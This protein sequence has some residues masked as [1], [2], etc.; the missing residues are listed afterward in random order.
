ME[1]INATTMQ[2]GYT[3]GMQHDGRDLL[4]VV[5]KGTFTIPQNGEEPKLADEQRAL[6]ETDVFTGEPGFSAP[7]YENDFAPR[8]PR[9]DVLLNGSAYAPHGKPTKRLCVSLRVGSLTKSFHVL[10][11]RVWKAGLLY[12]AASAPEP[13]TVMPI[14]YNNAFGGVDR[15]RE[16]ETQHRYYMLN[17]VGI[18]YH[19]YHDRKSLNGMPLPN[20]EETGKPIAK[21]DGKYRPMAFGPLGRAW[22]QRVKYAGTYD[23]N[24]IDNVFPFLPADFEDEYYQAAPEDQWMDY[25]KGGEVVELIN[26]LPHGGTVF[27]LPARTVSCEFFYKNGDRTEMNSVIDTILFEPDLGHFMMSWRCTLP[28][29]KNIHELRSIACS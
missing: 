15:S 12:T 27:Q 1:L 7:L 11:K 14:S 24:W 4:V 21:P 22:Q 18:G 8:K 28:L 6:V 5:V 17:H 29:R 16:D 23:Q 10:G 25:P 13:F 26:L 2:A 9:C 20:T 19:A 3:M